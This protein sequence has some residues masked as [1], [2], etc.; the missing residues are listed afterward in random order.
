MSATIPKVQAKSQ[1]SSLDDVR[2]FEKGK[3][4][5]ANF[6]DSGVLLMVGIHL[7]QAGDGKSA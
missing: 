5:V 6:A 1:N 7:N 4:E 2:T 3:T